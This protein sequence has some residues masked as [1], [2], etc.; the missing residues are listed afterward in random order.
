MRT[1]RSISYALAI[2]TT[3]ACF[4][5]TPLQTWAQENK[6]SIGNEFIP[7]DAVGTAVVSVADSLANPKMK[8]Y[9]IEVMDAWCL[10]NIGIAAQAIDTIQVIAAVPGPTG[11]M[12]AAVIRTN[13]DCDLSNMSPDM[14]NHETPISLDGRTCYPLNVPAPALIHQFDSK[15]VL[16]ATEN[17]LVSVLEAA[18][19]D[20]PL[21]ALAELADTVSHTGQFSL[22]TAMEPTRPMLMSLIQSQIN[23]IPP[24]MRSLIRVP[25]LVDAVT[26][27]IDMN[28]PDA[29]QRL[30]MTASDGNAARE[31]Q[32]ILTQ[33]I[34]MGRDLMVSNMVAELDGDDPVAIASRKYTERIADHMVESLTPQ[35]RG[36]EVT[37]EGNLDYSMATNG[38]LVGLLL[39]AVQSARAA[40]RRMSRANALKQIG[41]AMHNYHATYGSLPGNIVSE[42][43]KPLLSWRV[44]ILPFIEQLP[45]YQQFHLDEP[46]DS[47]HNI[48]L[49]DKM[50]PIYVHP[51]L[52]TKPNTTVHQRPIGKEKSPHGETIMS[53]DKAC[54]FRDIL[55]GTSMTI[56]TLEA[57]PS[58]AVAWTKP[59]DLNVDMN[60]PTAGIVGD[61]RVGFNVLMADGSVRFMANNVDP[62]LLKALLTRNGMETINRRDF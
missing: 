5:F 9:P 54:R 17:Y 20:R 1:E 14:V 19:D 26:V 21:G 46:W 47:E 49:I 41:L 61:T 6:K 60:K 55:D 59:M 32:H 52:Q 10:E 13:Q 12:M 50:P 43:G 44:A 27:S 23:Q 36:N 51:E 25:E 38:V 39:P 62:D 33:S 35:Q 8:L 3:A 40:A 29:S 42:D 34:A 24:P 30:T 18:T 16:V 53:S 56:L 28:N 37:I 48:K 57:L 7:V 31:L 22:V 4:L 2:L 58:E 11:P 15:T 45:L